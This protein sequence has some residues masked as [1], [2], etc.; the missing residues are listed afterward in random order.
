[1]R[2]DRDYVSNCCGAGIGSLEVPICQ[3]C[4]EH[5]EAVNIEEED[6]GSE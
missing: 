4:G 1:M 2:S 5:C 3:D 6:N